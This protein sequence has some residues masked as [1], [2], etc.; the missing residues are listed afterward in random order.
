[1][2]GMMMLERSVG[3]TC[4]PGTSAA[5]SP[6]TTAGN[7]LMVPRC[8]IRVEKCAGGAKLHCCCED[9]LACATLQ[10]LCKSL[11]DGLCSVHCLMNG[12]CV[13]QCNFAMCHCTCECT[14]D[15]VCITCCSGDEACCQMVQAC[16]ECLAQ[17]LAAG[18][19]CCVCF[20]GTPVC[21]GCC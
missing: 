9:E 13:C 8:T 10:N 2:A 19:N 5:A 16:C 15:G 21:C 3:T 18:C 7:T 11:C 1:M 20:S 17:C 6:A 14:P 12:I 4:L